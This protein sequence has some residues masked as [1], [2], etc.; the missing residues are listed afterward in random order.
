MKKA[1]VFRIRVGE[2]TDKTLV[3]D[4]TN[5]QSR[6][7][8]YVSLFNIINSELKPYSNADSVVCSLYDL[9]SHGNPEACEALLVY[10]RNNNGEWF[11]EIDV[12]LPQTNPVL[13]EKK[14]E[15]VKEVSIEQVAAANP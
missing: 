5:K 6:D 2:F 10:R 13:V 14:E 4:I 9:A 8:A 3:W 1:L 12:R 15:A 11:E 7:F